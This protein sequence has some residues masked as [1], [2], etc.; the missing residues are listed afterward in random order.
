[1]KEKNPSVRKD[2]GFFVVLE[3]VRDKIPYDYEV[4]DRLEFI[5]KYSN[6]EARFFN[7]NVISIER[8]NLHYVEPH[9]MIIGKHLFL[10]FN[11]R[12]EVYYQTLQTKI[13]FRDLNK[14]IQTL[15]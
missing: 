1:M 3:I 7:G 11:Y 8:T 14:F 9:K 13:D 10:F 5:C 6:R 4:K 12:K 15:D 2:G